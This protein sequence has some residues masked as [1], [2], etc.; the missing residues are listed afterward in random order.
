M[1]DCK[2]HDTEQMFHL[3]YNPQA[4]GLV[5]R[6]NGI[7]RCLALL[8]S[9]TTC[10]GLMDQS[11]IPGF[12]IFKWSTCKAWCPTY[13]MGTPAKAPNTIKALKLRETEIALS[14]W[15]NMLCCWE[16]LGKASCNGMSSEMSELQFH[17]TRGNY[18]ISSEILFSCCKLNLLKCT[19]PGMENI[20]EGRR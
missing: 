10:I 7:R 11:S 19:I 12:N 13:W 4:A 16:H 5:E 15:I 20:E 2:K 9:K 17:C 3:P 18:S 6:K 1:Q 14:L 8:T